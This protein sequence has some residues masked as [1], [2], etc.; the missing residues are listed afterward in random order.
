MEFVVGRANNDDLYYDLF[1]IGS[2]KVTI[3]VYNYMKKLLFQG[4]FW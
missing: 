3:M 4:I 1:I 2:I